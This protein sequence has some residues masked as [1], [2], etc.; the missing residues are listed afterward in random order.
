M[1]EF[2]LRQ[3][4]KT[5]NDVKIRTLKDNIKQIEKILKSLK[6]IS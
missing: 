6:E 5:W 3:M 2:V 4:V 1:K